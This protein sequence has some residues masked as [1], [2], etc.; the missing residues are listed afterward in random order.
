MEHH[1]QVGGMSCAMC[2]ARVEKCVAALPGV[3][4]VQVN[5]PARRM[6]VVSEGALTTQ[7]IADAVI[8]AGYS[9]LPEAA[10]APKEKNPLKARAL[11][12][13]ALLLP[14]VLL[15]HLAPELGWAQLCVALPIVWLNR[16]FFVRGVSML[17]HGTP[18]M[19]TLVALGAGGKMGG[20]AAGRARGAGEPA[21]AAHARSE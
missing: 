15:H 14:L 12:S 6:R 9:A 13:L 18:G 1:L 7:E 21:R 11:G 16:A 19:D 20:S 5:L 2:A 4:E 3:R 10:E 17:R 8:K